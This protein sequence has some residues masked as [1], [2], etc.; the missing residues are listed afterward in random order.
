VERALDIDG[1]DLKALL[2]ERFASPTYR[3]PLLPQVALDIVQLSQRPNLGFEEVVRV[4]EQ[5]PVLAAKVLSLAGSA[6]YAPRSPILSLNQAAVRLGLKTLRN[7]VL[8]ASLNLRVFRVPG[9]ERA[10][11]RLA[12]HCTAVA[13]ICRAVCRRSLVDAEYAFLCGLLHDVG[14]AGGLL[15]LAEDPVWKAATFEQLAP[16]LDEI[17]AE[18]GGMLARA[19]KLP[20]EV[21]KV[22]STHHDVVVD[23][24]PRPV[25]AA[26]VVAEQLV[27]EAG[28]GLLPPPPEA[29]PL[30]TAM[31]EPPIDG[32]DANWTGPVEEAARALRMEPL[33]LCAA[34]AE[35]FD[36][37]QK[38]G[39]RPA[40]RGGVPPAAGGRAEAR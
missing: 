1:D 31:P 33:A 3:P 8:E 27:W 7:L 37:L 23:G 35:A 28:V 25:N 9:Y 14:F 10:M 39:L 11:E 32:L 26:L 4:L 12:H 22:V 29:D 18:A 6:F 16:V 15:A 40:G 20:A 2:R 5:D 13:H 19:W 34:R 30:A 21:E 17:H 24:A 36:L 38:L